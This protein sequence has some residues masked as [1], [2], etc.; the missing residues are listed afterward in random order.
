MG[1][2]A[3]ALRDERG[4]ELAHG[5]VAGKIF[6]EDGFG[7]GC[8]VLGFLHPLQ[9]PEK[10]YGGGAARGEN[11]KRFFGTFVQYDPKSGGA[12]DG[13]STAHDHVADGPATSA[14]FR[15]FK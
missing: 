13:R 6:G 15:H 14:A 10:I 5:M 8:Q 12:A 1:H 4:A 3:R 11:L 7:L 2:D 9:R